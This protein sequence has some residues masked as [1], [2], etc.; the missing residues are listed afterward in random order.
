M[1]RRHIVAFGTAACLLSGCEGNPL[2]SE[3]ADLVVVEAFL[4]A[5]EPIDDIR[6]TAT[7]PLSDTIEPP[8]IN[9]ADVV[10]I[11]NGRA[12]PL[13]ATGEDGYYQYS[14]NEL[15]VETGDLFR[16]EVS[17]FGRVATGETVVPEPPVGVAIDGDTLFAPALGMGRGQRGFNPD[18]TQLVATWDNPDGLL[19][20]A[21]VEGLEDGVEAIFPEQLVERL[22]R[23]RLISQP[24]VDDFYVVSLLTLRDLGQHAVKIYRVNREYADLYQNRTQD[25]RDLNEP[26]SNITN[27]LGVFSAFNSRSVFFEV[28]RES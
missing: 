2:D 27:G 21:V 1:I 5:G 12:Y 24:T 17:Y 26:P 28:V 16:I 20:F 18:Q 25:S 8:T 10:L 22:A 11:K 9:D 3:S 19:H 23:F 13:E 14:G 4:F 6:L 7:V 15:V